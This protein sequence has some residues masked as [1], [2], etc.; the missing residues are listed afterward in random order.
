MFKTTVLPTLT[1]FELL[2]IVFLMTTCA[3]P[4]TSS[5][6]QGRRPF[7]SALPMKPPGSKGTLRPV[8]SPN[9]PMARGFISH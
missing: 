9:Q 1:G 2:E 5:T 8:H 7:R 3:P 6:D 4:T